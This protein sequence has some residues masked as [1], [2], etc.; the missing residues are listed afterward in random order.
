LT[1]KVTI[2]DI[3]T[4]SQLDMLV[5]ELLSVQAAAGYGHVKIV[6]GNGRIDFF[7]TMRSKRPPVPGCVQ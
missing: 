3:L 2:Q 1:H 4:P 7:E 6:I 5:Q